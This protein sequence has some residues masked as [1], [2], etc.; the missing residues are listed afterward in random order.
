MLFAGSS[1]AQG[2]GKGGGGGGGRGGGPP[3]QQQ[4]PTGGGGGGQGHVRQQPQP[5]QRQDRG[6]GGGAQRQQMQVQRQQQQVQRQQ[7]VHV[8][9]QQQMQQRQINERQQQNARRQQMD[10]NNQRQQQQNARRQQMDRGQNIL[11]QQQVNARRQQMDQRQ[12]Q[13]NAR[14]QQMPQ[15]QNNQ[16]EQQ[17]NARRQMQQRD[18]RQVERQPRNWNQS[19][20]QQRVRV[21][22]DANMGP[23]RRDFTNDARQYGDAVRAQRFDRDSRKFEHK[24]Q[25]LDSRAFEREELGYYTGLRNQQSF[26]DVY[27]TRDWNY[28]PNVQP[29]YYSNVQPYYYGNGQ[30]Y[31]YDSRTVNVYFG[32]DYSDYDRFGYYNVYTPAY[33]AYDY[34]YPDTFPIYRSYVYDQP[35]YGY[36]G[37]LDWKGLLFRSVIAAF[38][39]NGDNVGYYDP[40]PRYTSYNDNG[41]YGYIPQYRYQEPYYTFG[42]TPSYT[43][44]EPAAYYGYD[45]YSNYGAPYDYVGYPTFPYNDMVTLYSGGLGAELIQ[46]SLSTGY[47]QGLLEGE[48]ARRRGWGDE[49]Y[50]DPYVYD[51]AVYDPYS[52]SIGDCRRYFSEGYE[53]GYNDGLQGDDEFYV[54]RGGDIDL[55]SLLMTSAISLRS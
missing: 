24:Q 4:R 31:Y 6:G 18:I 5:Q 41:Y 25:R 50:S 1:F 42:N 15:W 22:P 8:Q 38:F 40:Y 13:Q 17:M 43:Y 27:R 36:G 52:S 19:D 34:Y 12:Q 54:D 23:V 55:V 28:V 3:A 45:Q 49:Y 21:Q 53:M 37:G 2:K 46:R 30:T 20:R 10:Q 33:T 9:R 39:S 11:R 47:Y 14:R 26:G 16:R 48:A 32:D 29:Y 7:Q 51:Q 44:Y 35:Y